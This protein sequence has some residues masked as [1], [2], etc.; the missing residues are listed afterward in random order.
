[1]YLLESCSGRL[2]DKFSV[3][4]P[5][6]PVLGRIC[7]IKCIISQRYRE[8]KQY[9]AICGKSGFLFVDCELLICGSW[10]DSI[11]CILICCL[12]VL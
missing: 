5:Q 1:M 2:Y 6:S 7:V 11:L 10:F 12:S 8:Y 9:I 3:I 4:S